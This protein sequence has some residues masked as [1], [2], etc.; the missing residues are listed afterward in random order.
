MAKIRQIE[1]G[2][3]LLLSNKNYI[4]F[5]DT[6]FAQLQLSASVNLAHLNYLFILITPEVTWVPEI[7]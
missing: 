3:L 7:K 2:Y 4:I 1:S 6:F 5:G